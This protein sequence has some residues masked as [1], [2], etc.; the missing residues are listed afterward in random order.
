M[1][2]RLTDA[3]PGSLQKPV[4]VVKGKK[5]AT[6]RLTHPKPVRAR[7][8]A[9]M[10]WVRKQPC[11]LAHTGQCF[12]A[13]ES[14]HVSDGSSKGLGSK[15]SDYRCL[16]LC[17]EAHHRNGSHALDRISN[18]R[19]EQLWGV[20]LERAISDHLIRYLGEQG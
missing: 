14:A 5:R 13:V 9:Y 2:H 10:A 4:R 20:N 3:P 8:D 11:I 7:S 16:P 15:V 12:G 18:W 19:F 6:A 1:T 17:G